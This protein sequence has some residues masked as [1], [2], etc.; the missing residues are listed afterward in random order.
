MVSIGSH[1]IHSGHRRCVRDVQRGG[2]IETASS[3]GNLEQHLV[4]A[5]RICCNQLYE[6]L[7]VRL[8]RGIRIVDRRVLLDDPVAPAALICRTGVRLT[9]EQNI[10]IGVTL[11]VD[12]LGLRQL[13]I[14]ARVDVVGTPIGNLEDITLRALRVMREV[15]SLP[16]KTRARRRSC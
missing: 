6:E 5:L 16:A 15:T 8:L 2:L 10:S 7:E 14:P 1:G 13:A 3:R 11:R 4:P 9:T 12:G